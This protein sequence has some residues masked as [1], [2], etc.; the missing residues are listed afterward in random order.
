MTDLDGFRDGVRD[1]CRTHVPDGWRAAQTGVTDDGF[2]A[3]QKDWFAQLREA[4]FAVPHWPAEWGGGMSTAEQVVLYQELAAQ[5][6]LTLPQ[7]IRFA[8]PGKSFDDGVEIKIKER[9]GTNRP[10]REE[11][12]VL[13]APAGFTVENLLCPGA[14]GP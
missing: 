14:R 5:G 4:G 12:F 7:V 1:W 9:L 2:V 11:S 10:L 3:F 8:E 6:E 13:T